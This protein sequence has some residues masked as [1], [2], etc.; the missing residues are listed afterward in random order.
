MID[1]NP[2][3]QSVVKAH[4]YTHL[5][6]DKLLVTPFPPYAAAAAAHSPT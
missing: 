3:E 1:V 6:H 4:T 2:V 5:V